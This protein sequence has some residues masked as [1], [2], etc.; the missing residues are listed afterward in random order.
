MWITGRSELYPIRFGLSVHTFQMEICCWL[1]QSMLSCDHRYSTLEI[2][3]CMSD[4]NSQRRNKMNGDSVLFPL[5]PFASAYFLLL[6]P[7]LIF[8]LFLFP[9]LLSLLPFIL[10]LFLS[11]CAVFLFFSHL[12]R[13]LHCF[14]SSPSSFDAHPFFS[15]Y[16]PSRQ[17]FM[18]LHLLPHSSTFSSTFSS[19]FVCS[20]FFV[21]PFL[22]SIFPI[23][24]F[25][26]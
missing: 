21:S 11:L 19:C 6:I 10:T 7:L 13:F 18:L 16:F 5:A 14:Y 26:F 22:S 2:S 12:F 1:C 15:I 17:V 24:F 3:P 4:L 9:C 8:F 25:H 20:F 23:F